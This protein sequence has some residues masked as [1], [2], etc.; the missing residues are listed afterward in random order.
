MVIHEL[1]HA[2]MIEALGMDWGKC[3]VFPNPDHDPSRKRS[4]LWAGR[5]TNRHGNQESDEEEIL[6]GPAGTVGLQAA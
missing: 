6:I 1:G 2:T 4:N 3:L 5:T